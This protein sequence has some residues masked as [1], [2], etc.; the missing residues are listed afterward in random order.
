VPQL[1]KYKT[2]PTAT[3][4]PPPKPYNRTNRIPQSNIFE[5]C[6]TG[7]PER[8]K[9]LPCNTL[10]DSNIFGFCVTAARRTPHAARCT[11]LR[12]PARAEIRL[13]VPPSRLPT[14][15]S[16]NSPRDPFPFPTA[17]YILGSGL[18]V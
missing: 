17:R 5:F 6:V 1:L 2:K 15:D 14:P 7:P 10:Q 13:A 18:G 12:H 11:I 8:R 9:P 3:P 4:A 16:L